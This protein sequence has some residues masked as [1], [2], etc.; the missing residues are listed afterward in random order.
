MGFPL[1]ITNLLNKQYMAQTNLLHTAWGNL[2]RMLRYAF[3]SPLVRSALSEALAAVRT[4]VPSF[5]PRAKHTRLPWRKGCRVSSLPYGAL[6]PWRVKCNEHNRALPVLPPWRVSRIDQTCLGNN[7]AVLHDPG[8]LSNNPQMSG[9]S[10][11]GVA[12]AESEERL[13]QVFE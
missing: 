6:V 13:R 2:L 3:F 1:E 10:S 5:C 11:E 9:I 12:L 4:Q 8:Q 7:G